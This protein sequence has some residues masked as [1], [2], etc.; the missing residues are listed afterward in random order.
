ML[1][2]RRPISIHHSLITAD[3]TLTQYLSTA[4]AAACRVTWEFSDN[5]DAILDVLSVPEIVYNVLFSVA[6]QA[7]FFFAM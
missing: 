5:I 6:A 7:F 2:H 4:A 3:M 1:P